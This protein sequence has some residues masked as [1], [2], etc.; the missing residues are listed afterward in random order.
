MGGALKLLQSAEVEVDLCDNYWVSLNEVRGTPTGPYELVC[1][2]RRVTI[3]AP[4]AFGSST[5]PGRR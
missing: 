3:I 2:W 4:P 1:G 5:R